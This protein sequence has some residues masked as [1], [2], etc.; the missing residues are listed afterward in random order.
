MSACRAQGQPSVLSLP[1]YIY[2][3]MVYL[4]TLTLLIKLTMSGLRILMN[5]E[6]V[7]VRTEGVVA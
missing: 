4:T 2:V 7:R 1:E 5:N 3:F 6:L